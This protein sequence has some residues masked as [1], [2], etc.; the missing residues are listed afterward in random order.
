MVKKKLE[1]KEIFFAC[2]QSVDLNNVCNGCFTPTMPLSIS[3]K[4]YHASMLGIHATGG[5]VFKLE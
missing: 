3:I 4:V 5:K 2:K 1:N